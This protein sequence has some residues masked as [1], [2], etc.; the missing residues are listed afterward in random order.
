M[1][2]RLKLPQA[3]FELLSLINTS[4]PANHWQGIEV[5]QIRLGLDL[6]LWTP[7]TADEMV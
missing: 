2:L 6:R 7:S 5:T 4:K 1:C 3:V